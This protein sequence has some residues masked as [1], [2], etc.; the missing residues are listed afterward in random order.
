MAGRFIVLEGLDGSGTTTQLARLVEAVDGLATC[1]PS[2][3]PIGRLIRQALAREAPLSERVLPYLFA[4]DRRDHLEREIEPAVAA[5]RV[6]VSDRYI[7]SSLAYQT[8]ACPLEL[9][10]GLNAAFRAP[11][12]TLYLHLPVDVCAARVEDRASRGGTRDIF[13]T[14]ERLAEIAGRYETALGVL[15]RAGH[16]IVRV[17]GAGTVDEVHARVMAEVRELL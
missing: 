8:L 11:G 3:G 2:D 5:G 16:R 4:A 10:W 6:I 15:E 13:E 1:E 12:L 17:D 9:V 14:R 7:G